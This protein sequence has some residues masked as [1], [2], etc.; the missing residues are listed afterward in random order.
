MRFIN[1]SLF[2]SG[3]LLT[4]EP[5]LV[6]AKTPSESDSY[7]SNYREYVLRKLQ[8]LEYDFDRLKRV[9][10]K[11]KNKCLSDYEQVAKFL[12][13]LSAKFF[14][15]LNEDKD[16]NPSAISRTPRRPFELTLDHKKNL[17][18]RTKFGVICTK[19]LSS[20]FV[21]VQRCGQKLNVYIETQ[22]QDYQAHHTPGS[23]AITRSTDCPE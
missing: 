5:V 9:F 11:Y 23:S 14:G 13:A 22:C 20:Y 16:S 18:H 7:C 6:S 15:R 21:T 1:T 19:S 12:Y 2:A 10:I 3:L 17:S 8:S 4:G